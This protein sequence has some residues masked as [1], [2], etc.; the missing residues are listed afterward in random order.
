MY[1]SYCIYS[2]VLEIIA[3]KLNDGIATWMRDFVCFVVVFFC[4]QDSSEACNL[5]ALVAS[6]EF[7][8]SSQQKPASKA[9]SICILLRT[10][11]PNF[12]CSVI[13]LHITKYL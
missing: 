5:D 6:K 11:I 1:K 4:L 10:K 9:I 8:Q 13:A 2:E 3:N 12:V 7:P